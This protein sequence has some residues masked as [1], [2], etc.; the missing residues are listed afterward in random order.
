MASP[1][2]QRGRVSQAEYIY[3]LTTVTLNRRR[4]FECNENA[5]AVI[6]ALRHVERSGCSYSLAWV[7]MPDH[8]H[9]LM[10]LKKGTLPNCMNLLKSRSSRLL[11]A[12]LSCG[13]VWQ[14][15]YY[16]HALRTDE[17]LETAAQYIVANPIRAGL[18]VAPGEYP[19]A[20]SR[21]PVW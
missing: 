5:L 16:D 14:R 7:V 4:L 19:H 15:G 11:N 9:W 21:W 12:H 10:Q 8:V 20:W 6:E 13:P 18:S 3:S 2:L 17:S 1:R